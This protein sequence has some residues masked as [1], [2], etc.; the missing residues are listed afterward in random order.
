M[1]D[2]SVIRTADRTDY[3]LLY[4]YLFLYASVSAETL[5]CSC[6]HICLYRYQRI[7]RK[8][9]EECISVSLFALCLFV[10]AAC[11]NEY[12]SV[13]QSVSVCEDEIPDK[14]NRKKE[15]ETDRLEKKTSYSCLP[16]CI[17]L[18][19]SFLSVCS[20]HSR[21]STLVT[22]FSDGED[23]KTKIMFKICIIVSHKLAQRS[24]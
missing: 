7:R 12:T 9:N 1:P 6:V 18:F 19:V 4:D 17:D 23:R 2:V 3:S 8:K 20:P 13:W 24:L 15:K 5:M 21:R 10:Y 16:V 22:V 11:L 14:T